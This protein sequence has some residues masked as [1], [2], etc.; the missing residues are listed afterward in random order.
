MKGYVK[1]K[2]PMWR[3]TMKRNIGPGAMVGLD[4]LYQQY[5]EKHDISEGVE[6]VE[7]LKHVKLRDTTVWEVKY[8]DE[9]VDSQ[10]KNKTVKEEKIDTEKKVVEDRPTVRPLIKEELSIND[11]LGW[12]V[13]VAREELPKIS[14]NKNLQVLKASLVQANKLTHKDTICMM[15]RKKIQ[16]MELTGR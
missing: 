7:W 11:V 1:N 4:E 14:G 6:F 9:N 16:D 13:R 5:G 8:E 10:S 15:L 3:H 2:S 12:S